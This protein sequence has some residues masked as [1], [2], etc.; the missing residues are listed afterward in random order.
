MTRGCTCGAPTPRGAYLSL[1]TDKARRCWT[2]PSAL[3]TGGPPG[4]VE[5]LRSL[6]TRSSARWCAALRTLRGCCRTDRAGWPARTS[7]ASSGKGTRIPYA[8]PCRC[9]ICLW[10]IPPRPPLSISRWDRQWRRSSIRRVTCTRA[11]SAVRR[12][13]EWVCSGTAPA[14]RSGSLPSSLASSKTAVPSS[15]YRWENP[16]PPSS[17]P[18]AKC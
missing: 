16:T 15:R 1:P 11:G 2:C 10:R 14:I 17:P 9:S 18:R 13:Q 7:T 3:L 5:A 8:P 4:V 12:F 6:Q